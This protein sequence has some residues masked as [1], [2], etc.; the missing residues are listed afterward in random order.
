MDQNQT[1]C[2]LSQSDAHGSVSGGTRPGQLDPQLLGVMVALVVVT[3]LN[4]HEVPEAPQ[5][6]HLR[7]HETDQ[8]LEPLR[9]CTSVPNTDTGIQHQLVPLVLM[10]T[11]LLATDES[12][13]EQLERMK[14]VLLYTDMYCSTVCTVVPC[15][16]IY[17]HPSIQC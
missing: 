11:L 13:R 7:G 6:F 15:V 16:C 3:G 10:G 12:H 8:S 1:S 4:L 2:R 14:L 5:V 9:D 17:I